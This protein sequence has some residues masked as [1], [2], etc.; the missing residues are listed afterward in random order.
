MTDL[1]WTSAAFLELETSPQ[2]TAFGI[3]RQ[4]DHLRRFPEMGS[5]VVRPR[6]LSN[7]RLLIYKREY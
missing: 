7:Y 4:V 3:V 1:V 2:A 6:T 5:R